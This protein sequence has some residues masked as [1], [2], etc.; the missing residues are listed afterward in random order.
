MK[1]NEG[2]VQESTCE[3]RT[4]INSVPHAF[5]ITV[6][7]SIDGSDQDPILNLNGIGEGKY[8]ASIAPRILGSNVISPIL[9]FRG[10]LELTPVNIERIATEVPA[11]I[12]LDG[13]RRVNELSGADH[14]R[15][16]LLAR[17]QGGAPGIRSAL[18]NTDVFNRLA[19]V[20]PFGLNKEFLGDDETERRREVIRRLRRVASR[21]NPLDYGNFRSSI[22]TTSY[23]ARSA[24]NGTLFPSLDA[25]LEFDLVEDLAE[26]ASKRETAV[27][28]SEDDPLFPKH[29]ID[30]ALAGSDVEVIELTGTHATPGSR[31]GRRHLRTAGDWLRAA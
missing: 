22:E 31:L 12:A 28:A 15:I 9:P 3:W 13:L 20:A 2:R 29:E 27:F 6:I 1:V 26:L 21:S 16:N 4:T 7:D 25:A 18:G 30:A 19:Y 14:S 8:S 17:S 23:M 10:E 5:D 24:L 11:L